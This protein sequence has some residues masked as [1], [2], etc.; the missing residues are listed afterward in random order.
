MSGA[1]VAGGATEERRA[2]VE[3][4]RGGQEQRD[5]AQD[6]VQFRAQVDVEFRPGGHG[7]HHRLEPQ[8]AGD[9]QLAQGGAVFIGQLFSGAVGLIGVRGVTDVAQFGQQ[10]GQR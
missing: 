5:P 9:P 2:A 4:D 3:D 10:P 1:Q 6:G 7:R 8:Q